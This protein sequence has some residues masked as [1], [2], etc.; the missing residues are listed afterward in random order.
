MT[1]VTRK[2]LEE[3]VKEWSQEQGVKKFFCIQKGIVRVIQLVQSKASKHI[4]TPC[5]ELD[6]C[7]PV[8]EMRSSS[9]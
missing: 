1:Y 8:N 2:E 6:F 7:T 9:S 3:G 5:T 4:Y